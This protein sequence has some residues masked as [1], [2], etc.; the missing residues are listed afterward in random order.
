MFSGYYFSYLDGR[1][2]YLRSIYSTVSKYILLV[3][4]DFFTILIIRLNQKIVQVQFILF[5]LLLYVL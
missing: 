5:A 2:M 3:A 1:M 4:I